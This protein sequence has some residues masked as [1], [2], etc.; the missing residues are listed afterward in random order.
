MYVEC[1]R[2]CTHVSLST[3]SMGEAGMLWY[4]VWF[5]RGRAVCGSKI[6]A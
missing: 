4:V 5:G 6:C 2:R 3:H 1:L